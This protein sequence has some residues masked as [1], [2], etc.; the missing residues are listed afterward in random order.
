MHTLVE[1]CLVASFAIVESV[2][3]LAASCGY[4]LQAAAT[5]CA[6]AAWAQTPGSSMAIAAARSRLRHR[7]FHANPADD[8]EVAMGFS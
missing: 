3:I 6:P 4:L 5:V 7:F 1:G 2:A 8:S